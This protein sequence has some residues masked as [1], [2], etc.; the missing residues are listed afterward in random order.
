MIHKRFELHGGFLSVLLAV[1]CLALAGCTDNGPVAPAESAGHHDHGAWTASSTGTVEDIPLVVRTFFRP[2]PESMPG[3]EGDTPEM[4][5][6]GRRLYFE[7]GISATKKQPCS[8]CH[9]LDHG[10]AGVDNEP[11][12]KGA[13]GSFGTR[14]SPTVL[15]AGFQISQ[16]WDGRAPDLAKQAEGPV[17]NPAEMAMRTED[18]V[19]ERIRGIGGYDQA[20]QRAFPKEAKAVS[21]RNAGRAIAAFERTLITPGRFDRYLKGQISALTEAEMQGM[22]RFVD[23]GCIDCHSSATVGGRQ[24]QTLGIH[25][26]YA[27]V[28]DLGRFE[29]TR[30]QSDKYTFKVPMLR[31]VTRTAPYFHD[32]QV[33]TLPEAVRL[34]AWLQLDTQLS[35]PQIDEIIRFLHTLE[36]ERPVSVEGP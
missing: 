21:L 16:F 4:V 6:L 17:M 9:P 19:V 23:T 15:N 31:N 30:R 10:K 28:K 1:G 20:F 3:S 13:K 12:S 27:N 32:G 25:H 2:L 8:E 22:R 24:F 35:R 33:A 26:P 34:M 11:T 36:A 18:E 5:S 7:P 29:V 14:N